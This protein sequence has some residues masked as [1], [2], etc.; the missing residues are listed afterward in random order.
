MITKGE[1]GAG[2]SERGLWGALGATM[3]ISASS[4]FSISAS[5]VTQSNEMRLSRQSLVRGMSLLAF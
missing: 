1:R 4:S 2:V 5:L 3:M